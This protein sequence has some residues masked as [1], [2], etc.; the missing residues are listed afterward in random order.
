M[1][2]NSSIDISLA[3]VWRS[4][5]AFRGGKKLSQAIVEFEGDL[6][7]NIVSLARTLQASGYTH[8]PYAHMIVNDNKRRDIAVA[9]VRDRVVHR[10]S[11]IISYQFGTR[12]SYMMR[13]PAAEIRGYTLL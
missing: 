4:Y 3:N 1:T 5:R 11:M 13:G 10:L 8:G 12:Y 2:G 7:D 6:L 9:S